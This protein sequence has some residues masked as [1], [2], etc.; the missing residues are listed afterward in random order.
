[1]SQKQSRLAL[2]LMRRDAMKMYGGGVVL[3]EVFLT[4]ALKARDH[5]HI[6]AAIPSERA[7]SYKLFSTGV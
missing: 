4:S 2:C 5:L 3:L 7:R 1:M 6:P